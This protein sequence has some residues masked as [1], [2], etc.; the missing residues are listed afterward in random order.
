MYIVIAII[1]FGILIGIHEL[2]H[3]LAAKGCGVRV[4]EFSIGMGPAILKKQKGETL[5]ALRVLPLG[6][7][8]AMEGENGDSSDERSFTRKS[9]WARLAVLF[10]GPFMN[11][12]LGLIVVLLLYSQ[13]S[14]FGTNA[15]HS[16]SEGFEMTGETALEVGDRIVS[17]DGHAVRYAGDFTLFMDRSGGKP[18][19]MVVRRDG[20]RLTLRQV[21][22]AKKLFPNDD[23]TETYRYGVTFQTVRATAG[24]RLKLGFY[25]AY[26]FVRGVLMG[27]SDLITGAV[28]LRDM[29]GAVGIVSV[30]SET[31]RSAPNARAAVMNISYISAFLAVNLAVMNL[32]PIPALDGGRIFFMLVVHALEKLLRRRIDPKYE[33]YIHAAG[34]ALLMAFM[35]LLLVNDIWRIVGR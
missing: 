30:I 7:Y 23:G 26:S 2:G 28:G 14:A 31:G 5:Y 16:F 1:V 13:V 18:V 24:E 4:N 22:L 35:A 19:D 29:S 32:L 17:I 21:L 11:F 3:F 9:V 10:A 15:I 12:L 34:M 8:C 33:G 20:E 27:L 25:Q 6:G